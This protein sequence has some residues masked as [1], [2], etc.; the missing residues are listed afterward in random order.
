MDFWFSVFN[1][2]SILYCFIQIARLTCFMSVFAQTL[3]TGA[4]L[5]LTAVAV[6][7]SVV[8][9]VRRTVRRRR[10]EKQI[11]AAAKAALEPLSGRPKRRFSFFRRKENVRVPLRRKRAP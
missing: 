8:R 1:V 11:N 4:V 10:V 9:R 2:S 7:V 5:A 3:L 6:C